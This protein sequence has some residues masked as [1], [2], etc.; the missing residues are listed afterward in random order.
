MANYIW[1]CHDC[2]IFWDRDYPLAKNPRRTKCPECK[3]LSERMYTPTPVHFKG[4]GWDGPTGLNQIGGSDEVNK[5]LQQESRERMKTG[6]QHYA[7][8]TAKPGWVEQNATLKR[9]EAQVKEKM[10]AARKMQGQV[11]DKAGLDR[12]DSLRKKPQ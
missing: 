2:K 10:E 1:Q 7:H 6:F 12:A 8:Y 4:A 11:Y 5:K 9:T 3:K